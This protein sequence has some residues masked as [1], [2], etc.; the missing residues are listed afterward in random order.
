LPTVL[1]CDPHRLPEVL[2]V[3]RA[4][5]AGKKL[6]TNQ[7]AGIAVSDLQQ[8]AE[9]LATAKYSVIAWT[10]STLDF[11]HAE[12]AI[13]NITGI[14]EKLNQTTRSAGLPLSG[15]DGDLGAYNASAWISGYPFRNSYRRDYPDYDPY[16]YTTE[17]MLEENEA[18]ALLWISSFS[19]ERVPPPS[20]MPTI[21]FGHPAMQLEREPDVF[22]P[23]AVPG[24]DR[25]GTQFRSDSS[26]ALPLKQLRPTN[27]PRLDEVLA[28]IE[29]ALPRSAAC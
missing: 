1:P 15:S 4:L 18:D 6:A 5:G 13:Q 23:I 27:L 17:K 29:A 24:M 28:A 21:V 3:L 19:P 7:V 16:H 10:A 14:V 9:R 26:V 11:P 8:L 22:I 12:L 2:G 20:K 25:K